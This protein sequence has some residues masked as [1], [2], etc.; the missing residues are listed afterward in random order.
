MVTDFYDFVDGIYIITISIICT[1][2]LYVNFSKP[3]HIN[4]LVLNG[5]GISYAE[6]VHLL[7][8]NLSTYC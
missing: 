8:S 1:T 6:M 2:Q 7:C 4:G 3:F 5:H